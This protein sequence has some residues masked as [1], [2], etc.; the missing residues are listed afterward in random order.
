MSNFLAAGVPLPNPGGLVSSGGADGTGIN[1]F[2]QDAQTLSVFFQGT[3]HL[4]DPAFVLRSIFLS[5]SR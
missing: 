4:R 5:D 3:F 2:N 1:T